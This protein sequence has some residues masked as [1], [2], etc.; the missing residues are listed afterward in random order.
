[1]DF[2]L[3]DKVVVVLASS[4]G[5]GKATAMEFAKEGAKVFITGRDRATLEA[6]KKEIIEAS[7]NQN[8]YPVKCDI[9]QVTD[10]EN[11]A[12][13]A[14]DKFGGVDILINNA[15]GPPAGGFGD[16]SD[17]MW[18]ES[19]EL[20]VMS[21]IRAIRLFLPEMKAQGHGRIVNFVSSSIKQSI[22]NL[23]LS[24]TF[25]AGLVGFTK[26]MS[27]ELSEYNILIN[28]VAPGR[29]LTD[30][31]KHLDGI[32]AEKLGKSYKEVHEKN[33]DQIPMGRY[34]DPAE[35]AKVVVFLSSDAN[36][37]MTGQSVLVDGGMVKAL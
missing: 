37:Y 5:L 26:S 19:F 10:L 33:A 22:D 9:T 23:I 21:F 11:L 12:K 14:K 31:T 24:N 7:E 13:I 30:R 20:N 3:K 17:Q 29:I 15:G 2:G 18:Q 32:V 1:M 6:T 28:N 36:T 8:I 25:R 34:G 16:I 35:F 27:Q 4:K